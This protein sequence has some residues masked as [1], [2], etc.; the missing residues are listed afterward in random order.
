MIIDFSIHDKGDGNPH[1]HALATTRPIK[2][3]G[4]WGA[5]EKKVY[6]LDENEEKIPLIDVLTGKQKVDKRNRKQWKRVMAEST[7]WNKK[8]NVERWRKEWADCCN[9]YLISEEQIDHRSYLRQGNHHLPSIHEGYRARKIA[10]AGHISERCQEN[11]MVAKLNRFLKKIYKQFDELK[12]NFYK[13]I[14]KWPALKE[15]PV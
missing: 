11:R 10:Q 1:C 15:L 7:G 4:S 14:N 2:K 8:E 9:R 12:Q 6:A 3:D 13:I 5:K